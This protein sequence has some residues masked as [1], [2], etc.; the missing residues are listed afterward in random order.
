MARIR[1][2]NGLALKAGANVWLYFLAFALLASFAHLTSPTWYD[3]NY[4]LTYFVGRGPAVIFTDYHVPNNHILYSFVLWFWHQVAGEHALS[5]RI[6]SLMLTSLAIP[7]LYVAGK[8]LGRRDIGLYAAIVFASSHV[9][10]DFSAQL[11]GYSLSMGLVGLGLGFAATWW[12]HDYTAPGHA[13]GYA[14]CGALAV[15][16]IPTNSIFVAAISAWLFLVGTVWRRPNRWRIIGILVSPALGLLVYVRVWPQLTAAA[17]SLSPSTYVDFMRE[18]GGALLVYDM[19]WF[20]PLV[21]GA[22]WR[23]RGRE[24]FFPFLSLATMVLATFVAPL[25]YS[26]PFSRNYVPLTPVIALL[27]AWSLAVLVDRRTMLDEQRAKNLALVIVAIVSSVI[28]REAVLGSLESQR[29]ASAKG[30]P[31]SLLDQYYH[32]PRYNPTEV[33]ASLTQAPVRSLVVVGDDVAMDTLL[34]QEERLKEHVTTCVILR[35]REGCVLLLG[36]PA[37]SYAT[38]LVVD[39]DETQA[40]SALASIGLSDGRYVL[41]SSFN[42]GNYFKIW[43]VRL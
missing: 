4:T 37:D 29:W 25:V 41:E 39:R 23:L 38:I 18:V 13:F 32:H 22:L 42:S 30:K 33:V 3:E 7:G 16:V 43:L 5:G 11:R 14:V 19:P 1:H 36:R 2:S 17:H 24:S 10:G 31:Q 15:G 28:A 26:A 6:L 21:L 12:K 20:L 35:G 34:A 27:Y 40:R 8:A 9:V